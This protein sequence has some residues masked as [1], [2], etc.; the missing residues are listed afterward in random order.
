M[1]N[2][3]RKILSNILFPNNIRPKKPNLK[4]KK[5]FNW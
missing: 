3:N 5:V 4:I 2:I 1:L